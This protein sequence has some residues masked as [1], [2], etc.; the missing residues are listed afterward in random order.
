MQTGKFENQHRE[1]LERHRKELKQ[2]EKRFSKLLETFSKREND[3]GSSYIFSQ[4]FI[5]NSISEF[6]YRPDKKVTFRAYFQKYEEIFQ[7]EWVT[8]LDRKK[9]WLL[10]GKFRTV[11]HEKYANF[12]PKTSQTNFIPGNNTNINKIIWGVVF[13]FQYMMAMFKS[14]KERKWGLHAFC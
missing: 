5:I 9:V 13:T 2:R 8:W 10:L 12:I 3:P 7:K 6:V 1:D 14:Y 4:D 11:E